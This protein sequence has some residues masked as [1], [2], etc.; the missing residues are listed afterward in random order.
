MVI[1]EKCGV[2][3]LSRRLHAARFLGAVLVGLSLAGCG[4]SSKK[5]N[6][7][8]PGMGKA[9]VVK[10]LGRPAHTSAQGDTEFLGYNLNHAGMGERREFAVKLVDGKVEAF[11]EKGDFGSGR[12]AP[13]APPV[14]PAPM[15]SPAP[16]VRPPATNAPTAKP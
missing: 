5:L 9:Q 16:V 7:L 2:K 12:L 13:L 6:L 15:A 8:Q 10:I 11:G 14:P 3:F 1:P 4:T